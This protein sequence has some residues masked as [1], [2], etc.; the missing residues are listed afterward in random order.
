MQQPLSNRYE[1]RAEQHLAMAQRATCREAQVAHLNL[2]SHLAT[3][4][5]II[6]N[7]R[8]PAVRCGPW[9]ADLNSAYR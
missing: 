1:E 9:L 7:A 6:R 4:A 8:E 2:A 3:E 5:E